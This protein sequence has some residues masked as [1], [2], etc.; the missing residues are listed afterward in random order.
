MIKQVVS[1]SGEVFRLVN[2]D[3]SYKGDLGAQISA[4]YFSER[5]RATLNDVERPA[6]ILNVSAIS[7]TV[8][9]LKKVFNRNLRETLKSV[10]RV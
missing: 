6:I 8:S 4:T 3:M 5:M 7:P 9:G 1:K 10:G 2:I